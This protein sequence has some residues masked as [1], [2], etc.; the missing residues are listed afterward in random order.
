MLCDVYINL[1]LRWHSFFDLTRLGYMMER[2][3][4]RLTSRKLVHLCSR[5]DGKADETMATYLCYKSIYI[6]YQRPRS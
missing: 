2:K 1:A 6:R 3:G 5:R 4:C